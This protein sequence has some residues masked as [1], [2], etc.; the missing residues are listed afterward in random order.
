M[1]LLLL[2]SLVAYCLGIIAFFHHLLRR[3]Q[4]SLKAAISAISLG[5]VSHSVM[6]VG[7]LSCGRETYSIS[8]G[9]F[10][11]FSWCIVLA[12]LVAELRFKVRYISFILIPIAMLL[13]AHSYSRIADSNFKR[14]VTNRAANCNF[15][16]IIGKLNS[17]GN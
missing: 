12:C 16:Y 5:F 15:A 4:F 14:L 17:I 13:L 10:A 3:R 9:Y 2:F 6:L 8:F 1:Y 7:L 11:F